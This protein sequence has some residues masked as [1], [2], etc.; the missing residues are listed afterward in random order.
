MQACNHFRLFGRKLPLSDICFF[1]HTHLVI[2][3]DS[4]ESYNMQASNH[5]RLFGRKLPLSDKVLIIPTT[6]LS[7]RAS[8]TLA[9]KLFKL[10]FL[11]TS[12]YLKNHA[13]TEVNSLLL[14]QATARPEPIFNIQVSNL[15]RLF[16]RKLPL[17]DI[18]FL[19]ISSTLNDTMYITL[20][21][22]LLLK[23]VT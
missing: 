15:Y 4:E 22:Y 5:F 13:T 8:G 2:Q 14:S 1:I 17:S 3:S 6:T 9:K 20:P 18:C 7:F 16:G 23:P 21:F 12:L 10:L 19:T 11:N